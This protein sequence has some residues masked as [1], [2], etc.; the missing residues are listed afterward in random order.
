MPRRLGLGQG[1]QWRI[2]GC[3]GRRR[4]GWRG[5][6]GGGARGCDY[7]GSGGTRGCNSGPGRMTTHGQCARTA[8]VARCGGGWWRWHGAAVEDDRGMLAREEGGGMAAWRE[9]VRQARAWWRRR[10]S[11]RRRKR[12]KIDRNER[13]KEGR[14]A[15]HA[16][17]GRAGRLTGHGG[18]A[19]G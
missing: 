1:C 13:L 17:T 3:D 10:R 12:K 7:H 8:A 2:N 19:F 5:S 15:F 16:M 11:N 4:S 9:T 6:A 14:S 18:A